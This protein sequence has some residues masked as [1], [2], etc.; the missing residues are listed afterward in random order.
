MEIAGDRVA[1]EIGVV[2]TKPSLDPNATALI[3]VDMVKGEVLRD[4]GMGRVASAEGRLNHYYYER[5]ERVVLPNL[6]TLLGAF[7]EK[8]LP[9]VHVRIRCDDDRARDWPPIHRAHAL[10]RQIFPCRPG[11][12]EYEWLPELEPLPGEPV[13]EKHSVS[14]FNS[15]GLA[16]V[17]RGMGARFLVFGGVMTNYGVGHS[18]IDSTD[19]GFHATMVEDACAAATKQTHDSWLTASTDLYLRVLSTKRVLAE[20]AVAANGGAPGG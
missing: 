10:R 2:I 18:A 4:Y 1:S 20:L 14:V 9:I 16:G 8:R 12:A 13:M 3:I 11:L 7:R 15:T 17:L 5:V 6:V 19:L